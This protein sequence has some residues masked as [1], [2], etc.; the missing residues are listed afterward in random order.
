MKN[1]ESYFIRMQRPVETKEEGKAIIKETWLYFGISL[2]AALVLCNVAD[3]IDN[4][5]VNAICWL[6]GFVA[7]LA[8]F[9]FGFLLV[10]MYKI[11]RKQFPKK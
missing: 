6:G 2:A 1:K 11:V 10:N 8:T 5:A 9:A 3:V 7:V 4:K